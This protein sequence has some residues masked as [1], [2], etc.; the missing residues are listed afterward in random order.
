MI[1][2]SRPVFFSP[3]FLPILLFQIIDIDDKGRLS[4]MY[5][6]GDL[7]E[8]IGMAP[9]LA[10]DIDKIRDALD[11]GDDIRATVDLISLLVQEWRI[12]D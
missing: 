12:V 10:Q 3:A 8:G 1:H 7:K 9:S 6:S 5:E 4:L 11:N 2:D